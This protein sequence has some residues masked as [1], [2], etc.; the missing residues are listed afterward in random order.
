VSSRTAGP[1]L[2]VVGVSRRFGRRQALS[3]ASL[4][5]GPSEVVAVVGENGAGKSTLLQICAGLLRPDGGELA[6]RGRVGYCPQDADLFGL[7]TADEHLALFAPALGLTRR[8]ARREGRTLL[9]ELGFVDD[10][11]VV[12]QELS[13]GACQKLNLALALLGGPSLLLLDEPYQGF[14]RGAYVS[15]WEHVARWRQQGCATVIVTHLLPDLVEVDRV[16]ELRV[17]S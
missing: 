13:G 8:D 17:P 11:P 2:R 15:F 14:D 3:D 4:H 6:I 1:L 16:I 9:A 10:A 12:V 5:V 7:L